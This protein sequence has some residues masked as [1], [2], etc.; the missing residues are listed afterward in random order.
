[1]A[2]K[3]HSTAT[4]ADDIPTR[5]L[6]AVPVALAILVMPGLERV[7]AE[8]ET[9]VV[10]CRIYSAGSQQLGQARLIKA[11]SAPSTPSHIQCCGSK[12]GAFDAILTELLL[13]TGCLFRLSL[14]L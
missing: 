10:L 13:C 14:M 4:F 6:S 2:D 12:L 1:M 8:A 3:I 11:S 5:H 7:D 9:L